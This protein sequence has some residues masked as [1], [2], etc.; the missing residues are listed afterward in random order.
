MFTSRLKKFLILE[1]QTI[2]EAFK[3]IECNQARSVIVI[4]P[5]NVVLGIATDGD[6][7][8]YLLDS[9]NLS[10]PV[11]LC[12]NKNFKY[13][14]QGSPR[15][16]ILRAL[17]NS[18]HILPI[19]D[20]KKVLVDVVTVVDFPLKEQGKVIARAKSP[21]RISF[22]GGGTDLTHYFVEHGGAV[23][24]ATVKLYSRAS[25]RKRNESQIT[26]HSSDLGISLTVKNLEALKNDSSMPLISAT[27]GLINP[28]FGFELTISSDFPM[29]SGLGGS[30]V[31]LSAIIGCF[32]EFR[33][34]KWDNYE[35]AELAFQ[36]ERLYL[37]MAGG[38]QDQYATVFGG[39][40]FMEFTANQNIVH[41]LR[42]SREVK[43]ELEENLLLC[44]TNTSH[45]SDQLHK[46][47]Q[48]NFYQ[49][50]EIQ[51]MVHSNKELAYEMR[52]YLLKQNLDAFASS[53][54]KAWLLKRSFSNSI[55]NIMLD[56]IYNTAIESG[57]LGGKLLGAGGGGFFLFYVSHNKKASFIETMRKMN[58]TISSVIFDEDGLQ[59]W[60]MRD[61][62]YDE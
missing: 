51:S 17:N 58:C 1:N 56:N 35:I 40:N 45:D 47:Q 34:D 22:S 19:V 5:Q 50:S 55:S 39:F 30:S 38:W 20:S 62:Q 13:F 36:A 10:S 26:I 57:A 33:E 60:K 11:S 54:H 4:S 14:E 41:S 44:Y 21:V 16:T 7:R 53:L 15:E 49:N 25:L 43:L 6:I 28:D 52:N 29:K 27:I 8:R 18:T 3:L 61:A 37:S 2:S 31:V 48:D 9:P 23:L 46:E 32:N 12:M 59:S 24:N 42:I